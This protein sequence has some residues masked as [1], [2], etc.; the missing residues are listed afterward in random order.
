[1]SS[2]IYKT[3]Q[4][5]MWDY[6]AYKVYGNEKYMNMLLEANQQYRNYVRLPG[7]LS[8]VCPEITNTSSDSTFLPPWAV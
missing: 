5:E 2:Y 6:I 8:L 4:G 3:S 7:G 1:M